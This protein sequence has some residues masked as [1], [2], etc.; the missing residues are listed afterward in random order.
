LTGRGVPDDPGTP[1][2]AGEPGVAPPGAVWDQAPVAANKLTDSSA[3]EN[4]V[5]ILNSPRIENHTNQPGDVRRLIGSA[6]SAGK[7]IAC[8]RHAR[9][10]AFMNLARNL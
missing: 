10:I 1:G 3:I 7:R 2:V 4:L 6:L 9:R 8:Q 5:F